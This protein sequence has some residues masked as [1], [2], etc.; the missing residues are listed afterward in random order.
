MTDLDEFQQMNGVYA[1][2][3]TQDPPARAAVQVSALLKGSR[4]EIDAI[5]R[6]V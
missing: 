1:R 4:V 6:R 3:F 2:Y 5:A